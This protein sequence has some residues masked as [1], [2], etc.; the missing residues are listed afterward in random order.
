[1]ALTLQQNL[2]LAQSL[3]ITPQLQQAIKLLQLSHIELIDVVQ[4]ELMENPLLEEAAEVE[5][6]PK[7]PPE[8]LVEKQEL[9]SEVP[10]TTHPAELEV[11]AQSTDLSKEPKDFDWE[12]YLNTY[13]NS[14]G[15]TEHFERDSDDSNLTYETAASSKTSLFDHLIWQLHLSKLSS[16]EM[17]IGAEII[18]NFDEDGYLNASVD[19]I[20]NQLNE[21]VTPEEVE[22][23]LKRIQKFDPIGVGARSLQEC[24]LVQIEHLEHDRDLLRNLISNFMHELE[25]KDYSR[26]AR[27]LKI[28][29]H[30]VKFLIKTIHS[31]DPKPGRSISISEAQYISPDV[32]V[33]KVGE[34]WVILLN[35]DGLPRLQVSSY[36][37][38]MISRGS[39][40]NG[41]AEAK[42][43]VQGK[44][45]NAVWLIRSI[46][47]RQK[48]LYKTAKTIVKLQ[49]E[50]FEH[51]IGALK[52]MTIKDVANEIEMHESTVSRVTTNKYMHTPHGILELKF[53]FSSA[54]STTD[55]TRVAAESIKDKI[56]HLIS[57]E[58]H[59]HPYSDQDIVESLK[60]NNVIIARRT[61]AKYREMLG[62]LPSSQRKHAFK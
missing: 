37:K 5:D 38:N 33:K 23:V 18:G 2:K 8:I 1:M 48:T 17:E 29:P 35:E 15:Q 7:E 36:Y 30:K 41:K 49:K 24:L 11:G 39:N 52:P 46:Q 51:G 62:I 6:L 43:Y 10:T 40:G 50:F 13:N 9:E 53:F 47:Q 34:E 16:K 55:G 54:I 22:S 57:S 45:R 12:N 44:L 28:S 42:E 3:V 56:K 26:I 60:K 20:T 4:Q 59:G 31:L 61:I 32:Y 19:E 14:Y 27:G 58:D 21:P 25:R